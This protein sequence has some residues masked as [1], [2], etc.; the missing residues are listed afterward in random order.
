MSGN[1]NCRCCYSCIVQP[2]R[3]VTHRTRRAARGQLCSGKMLFSLLVLEVDARRFGRGRV[4]RGAGNWLASC[5][6][7]KAQQLLEHELAGGADKLL[8][9][10]RGKILRGYGIKDCV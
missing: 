8:D 1:A 10:G 4:G 7:S 9:I 2:S 3:R 5:L 6:G